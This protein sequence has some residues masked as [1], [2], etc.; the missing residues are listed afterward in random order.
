MP[1]CKNVRA[2]THRK[3]GAY[4][5]D[6]CK[7]ASP[8]FYP[9]VIAETCRF[10]LRELA[11]YLT[12][13]HGAISL[14][15]RLIVAS[16]EKGAHERPKC[17]WLMWDNTHGINALRRE[18][19]FFARTCTERNAQAGRAVPMWHDVNAVLKNVR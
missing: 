5:S 19:S 9:N 13:Q 1:I 18:E 11:R 3:M 12:E 4:Q 14:S 2:T 17:P 15:A 8:S 7:R 10:Q 6:Q 16:V